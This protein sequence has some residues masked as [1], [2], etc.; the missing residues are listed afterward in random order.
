MQIRP[1]MQRIF[2]CTDMQIM[3][4]ILNKIQKI[5]TYAFL[6]AIVPKLSDLKTVHFLAHHV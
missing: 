6:L 1:R 5:L 2:N 3:N 4:F